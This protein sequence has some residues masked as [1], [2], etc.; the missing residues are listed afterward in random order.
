MISK[1][2]RSTRCCIRVGQEY[3]PLGSYSLPAL[4]GWPFNARPKRQF[5]WRRHGSSLPAGWAFASMITEDAPAPC[6]RTGFHISSNSWYVPGATRIKSPGAA[7]SIAVWMA[8][9]LAL[10]PFT[11]VGVLP[12]IVTVTVSIDCLPFAE[13]MTSC[14][15]RAELPT[16]AGEVR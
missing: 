1:G 2:M 4:I 11:R 16:L 10:G 9:S 8:L 3:V 7:L 13:V 6:R 5:T 12:A 15:Q 14:A